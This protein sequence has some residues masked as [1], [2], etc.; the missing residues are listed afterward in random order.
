MIN[1]IHLTDTLDTGR[2][3][4]IYYRIYWDQ[5]TNTWQEMETTPANTMVTTF[6]WN[7]EIKN[8]TTYQFKVRP[9]NLVGDQ[10]DS[11]LLSVIPS[12]PPDQMPDP[13]ITLINTDVAVK[14]SWPYP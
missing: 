14:I 5:G 4:V 11:P 3:P 8:G 12:S 1:W 13:T 6:T 9:K 10:F 2:D 7:S